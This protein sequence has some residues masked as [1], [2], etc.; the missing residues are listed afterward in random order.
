MI[1][2]LRTF[3]HYKKICRMHFPTLIHTSVQLT[4][5]N[6]NDDNIST[7]ILDSL[8][9]GLNWKTLTQ[10]FKSVGFTNHLVQTVLLQLKE[11]T[12][13]RKALNLF[14]WSAKEM[15]VQH[16]TSTFCM[17]IHILVKGRLI[18]DAKALLETVLS[19]PSSHD[20]TRV[21]TVLDSLLNTYEAVDSVAFVFDLFIRT[22]AK[23]RMVDVILDACKLLFGHGF[24]L[25]LTTFNTLLHVMQKSGKIDLLWGVYRHMIETR[26]C[27]DE[28]TMQIMVNALCKE[29]KLEKYLDI[30]DRMCGT[31]CSVSAVIVNTCLVYEMIE[32][33]WI[34][35]GLLLLKRMLQKDVMVDTIL[36]S[37]I[38]FAKVKMGNL[39]TAM[40]IYKE[41]L[42][43]GYHENSFVCSLFIGAYC[44][45]GRI[46]DAIVLLEKMETLGFKTPSETFSLMIKGCSINGRFD[47]GLVLC[48]K[49]VRLGQVPSCSSVS[50]M[51]GKL[52]ENG[53]T[54]QA[55]EILTIL[56]DKGFP[57]DEN[58]FSHLIY[59][60][61]KDGNIERATAILFE[62]EFRSL[63]PDVSA[64]TSLIV[65]LCKCGRLTEADKYLE[66]MKSRSLLPSPNVYK[67]LISSHLSKGH[68]TR[69]HQ[70]NR[71][72]VG[73]WPKTDDS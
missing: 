55:D 3:S 34:E 71:E 7:L 73:T 14:H 10:R 26:V 53:R 44:E 59:G 38:V 5:I 40:E 29:G 31:R 67:E 66:M 69:A 36:Y 64:F 17:T 8:H 50:E 28:M 13:S 52:C 46:D 35:D 70:L 20:N 54:E 45:E 39:N 30:V 72:M 6:S 65:G 11:P 60:Y 12:N 9:E 27:P 2:L 18:K 1:N 22:C 15:N 57:F 47:D 16:G 25:N 51:I 41:M 49:M 23:L 58:T 37:L 21:L 62:M 61:C 42:N 32:E 68:K 19:N 4:H 48:K 43:R 33:D 56:L 63:S 24:R